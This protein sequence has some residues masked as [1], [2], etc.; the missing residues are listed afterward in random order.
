M[1]D[2]E[3]RLAD[4]QPIITRPDWKQISAFEGGQRLQGYVPNNNGEA[5][6]NSGVTIATGFDI[7]QRS[8]AEI[9]KFRPE[10]IVEK[11]LPY[12]GVKGTEALDL[13]AELPLRITSEEAS[14]IDEQVGFKI[15]AIVSLGYTR[16]MD[17]HSAEWPILHTIPKTVIMSMAWHYGPALWKATPK[18][19]E[20]ICHNNWTALSVMLLN[21]PT[22]KRWIKNRRALEGKL[23]LGILN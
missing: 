11:L 21:F 4:A 3:K 22:E 19:W 1:R 10:S 5:I 9:L 8:V 7:G 15:E 13:L 16:N 2:Q 12:A 14:I 23:L 6:G 20:L 17:I 18:C